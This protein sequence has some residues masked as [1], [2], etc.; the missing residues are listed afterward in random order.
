MIGPNLLIVPSYSCRRRAAQVIRQ[1]FWLQDF[2]F[3]SGV[4]LSVIVTRNLKK[5][6]TN[7]KIRHRYSVVQP[8]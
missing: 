4:F 5:N 2:Q 1:F 7:L 6:G 8:A 3:G